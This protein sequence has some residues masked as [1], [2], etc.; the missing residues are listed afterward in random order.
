MNALDKYQYQY[1]SGENEG[2][3]NPKIKNSGYLPVI[4]SALMI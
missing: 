1:S 4:S 3:P 2:K